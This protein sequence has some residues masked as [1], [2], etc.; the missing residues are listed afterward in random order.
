MKTYSIIRK[1][2][3]TIAFF[4]LMGA[5]VCG[6]AYGAP[7]S[8]RPVATKT[9]GKKNNQG[10]TMKNTF[11]VPD[12]AY[13]ET[14]M[15]NARAE[16]AKALKAGDGQRALQGAIQLSVA[17]GL[18]NSEGNVN[19][20]IA[21]FDTLANTLPAPWNAMSLIVQA[22]LYN[23]IYQSNQWDFNQRR[24]PLDRFPDNVLAWSKDMFAI[25]TQ[26]CVERAADIAGIGN[27]G[28]SDVAGVLKDTKDAIAARM[29]VSDF[30]R[31][32]GA[33]ALDVYADRIEPLRFGD[34]TE[35]TE[36]QKCG[37]LQQKLLRAGEKVNKEKGNIELASEFAYRVWQ[38]IE[39]REAKQKYLEQ[40]YKEYGNTAYGTYFVG[41]YLRDL[42]RIDEDRTD[43]ENEAGSAAANK[44]NREALEIATRYN[45]AFPTARGNGEVRAF[46]E[47]LTSQGVTLSYPQVVIPGEEWK[48]KV[49]G[50]NVYDFHI[51]VYKFPD[52]LTDNNIDYDT[53][54]TKGQLITTV[55]VKLTGSTPDMSTAEVEM[56]L[57]DAGNYALFA[58]STGKEGGIIRN[59]QKDVSGHRLLVSDISYFEE[60]DRND[61]VKRLYVVDART[62][63]PVQGAKVI[64]TKKTYR[65][66]AETKHLTTDANGCVQLPAGDGSVFVRRGDSFCDMSYWM[67]GRGRSEDKEQPFGTVLTDLSIYKPGETVRFVA[68]AGI[69]KGNDMKESGGKEMEVVLRDANYQPIDTVRG[70]TD[71]YGRLTGDFHVPT[72]GL[73]GSYVIQLVSDSR[74]V[75]GTNVQVADYKTP[76]F[77]VETGKVAENFKL[78]DVLKIEGDA[79][80][81]SGMPVAG[82]K[83]AY[84]V[85]YSP[86]RW[87]W[88]MSESNQSCH[89]TAT[90]DGDGRFVIELPTETL[91]GT[92][93]AK[94][95]FTLKVD[96]T[97][98]A[99]ETRQAPATMFGM[100]SAYSIN[101]DVPD[102]V[103]LIPDASFGTVTVR[104]M[105][106]KP[107]DKK[108]YYT[109]ADSKGA[110]VEKG[111]FSPG[112]FAPKTK[113]LTPGRY[114]ITFSLYEDMR[115][116]DECRNDSATMIVWNSDEKRPPVE[117]ALWV[118]EST[119]YMTDGENTLSVPVGS[120]YK[121][122]YVYCVVDDGEKTLERKWLK[123][124]DRMTTVKVDAPAADRR[125]YLH[126]TGMHDLKGET[127]NVTVIPP[128]QQE[129]VEISTESFRDKLEPGTKE[130]WKFGF[131]VGGKPMVNRPVMAVMSNQ[132]LNAIAPF[133]WSFNPAAMCSWS[134]ATSINMRQIG[135][136]STDFHK[137]AR[138]GG[139]DYGRFVMPELNTY[140]YGLYDRWGS[141]MV[142]YDCVVPQAAMGA[143]NEMKM[144]AAP[145]ELRSSR[146][147]GV[148][149]KQT[150]RVI[151]EEAA[152]EELAE[153]EVTEAGA[154]SA[155][156]E[157]EVRPVE[158]P[159]A[160]FMPELT[161][162]GDGVATL[163]FDVPQFNG[164]WQLQ[165]AGYDKYMRGG[166][167]MLTAVATKKVMVQMNAPRFLRTGDKA[168]VSATLFNNSGE[169]LP[170]AGRIEILNA[171]GNVL[172]AEDFGAEET[173][174]SGSRTVTIKYNVPDNLSAVTI[175]AYAIGGNHRDGEGTDV[176][177]LPSSTP[178]IE[179]KSFY[180]G[181]GEQVIAAD[182]P[183]NAKDANVTLQYCGNPV[184]E[185]VTALPDIVT[186]KSDNILSQ[187]DALYG[188][189][190]ASGLIKQFPQ[191]G[192]ALKTFAA[193][194]NAGDS[195][196]VS[197]L[198]KNQNLKVTTL[199]N[200]PWVNDAKNETMRMQSL[201]KYTDT[202]EAEAAVNAIMNKLR[203][204]Q[205]NDGGWS[206]CDNMPTSEFITA[207][208]LLHFAML[209]GMGYMPANSMP[210]LTKAF[211]YT[212]KELVK[213]WER[214][215]RK[216]ISVSQL[217]NYLYV[218]SFFPDV[219][220]AGNFGQMRKV[221]M[222]E[223]AD[224]WKNFD[225]YDKAV[226]V[227]LEHRSGNKA[228][229]GYILESLRQFATVSP[230][231]GMCF[232]NLRG[233]WSGWSPLI[234]TAQVLEAYTEVQ[235]EAE[236]VDRLRQWLLMSKQTQSWSDNR[237]TAEVI[238]ALLS[239]GSDW[240]VPSENATVTVG[241]KEIAV[242]KRA[243]L[244][245]SFTMT[246]TPDMV[247]RGDIKIEKHSAGPAWGGVISQYVAPIEDVKD[248][249]V[250]QLSIFKNIY[251]MDG[252]KA[253]IA[254]LK[255]GD[256]VRVT[257]TIKC[258]RDL[259]YVAVMDS[260]SA[261]LEPAGQL[262]GYTSSDGVWYY[263]EV[264]NEGTNLFIPFLGKGTHVLNY[265]CYVDRAGEY[266]LGIAQAQSQYAPVIT[267]HSAGMIIN[268]K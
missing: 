6:N 122:S 53:F 159:L 26:Q 169:T 158:C 63:Q 245:D 24:L 27:Y 264:R 67:Y 72:D 166:V 22:Q 221:A 189:A 222:K 155:V 77:K 76:T 248:Q 239:S 164:T 58:S 200:T 212:D 143:V 8:K 201:I 123:V 59:S 132:A 181:P 165:I 117:T 49:T 145:V 125:I 127:W 93:Y 19:D 68:V 177:V 97:D 42:T 209:K 50:M 112:L 87:W 79:R 81:Y 237:A 247:K 190:I 188:N 167:K 1:A 207:R 109:I 40:C 175:R 244:T 252:N 17:S 246:L 236:A 95:L 57:M 148:K 108:I 231:K 52:T 168:E 106:G 39:N 128:F 120:S 36:A 161:T 56:P 18:V 99:G 267:A 33:Q 104:D 111:E 38:N 37:E 152:D 30:V 69:R 116:T 23:S 45:N 229:S 48:C 224:G 16:Y 140:G 251:T 238:H 88:G 206:W 230:E 137:Y 160:F 4:C 144:D 32:A 259:D 7:V 257:L 233:V 250:P 256:K 9:T 105:T 234:T 55:P 204:K 172:V 75:A 156:T 130:Q 65:G 98:A 66:A 62:Q 96:V 184:W 94:G 228:L 114:K 92:P 243:K 12:F 192:E 242:P 178:V 13:P 202:K 218:K 102:R 31:F 11:A 194:E 134:T 210:M 219:K 126:F 80:T 253:Q 170:L 217:L 73:L 47:T 142:L 261:C 182:I 138:L 139:K 43:E 61:N 71:T 258:D 133:Q 227:I 214:N 118:P 51:M 262:S 10:K 21:R 226:A 141:G 131:K 191:L 157:E 260:R 195:T 25:R 41:A 216:Y 174:A 180:A 223:I 185:C 163:D 89:G 115:G 154:G 91:K 149:M 20:N 103:R 110:D 153:A 28:I 263:R 15:K 35:L 179:S 176:A 232:E 46:I 205:N 84:T 235:P 64:W 211:A 129:K 197:H 83:V 74:V 119:Y 44:S 54:R 121:D 198:E 101:A 268:V 147:A 34:I 107:A 255:T 186:P 225:I 240:T 3:A 150:A 135:S 220:D 171:E 213:E 85:T 183:S 60:T 2:F 215:K 5:P 100:A 86:W 70:T 82:A 124:S 266:S 146:S 136:W 208:V 78:G 249:S 151:T 265:E 196:L 14:V 90:T 241:G 29:T 173:K 113:A 162:D 193:P 203:E 199:N 187:V 254:D